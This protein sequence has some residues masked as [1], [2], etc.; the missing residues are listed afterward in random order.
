MDNGG[1]V[2]KL[3][4]GHEL[5]NEQKLEDEHELGNSQPQVDGQRSPGGHFDKC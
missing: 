3:E 2:Q 1:R 4:D 5:E